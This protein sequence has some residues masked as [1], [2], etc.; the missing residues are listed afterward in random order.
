MELKQAIYGR[1]AT[2]AYTS[3]PVEQPL[4]EELIDAAIQ[5][6]SAINQQPWAF[7]IVRDQALLERISREA[8]ALM[9]RSSPAGLAS[10]HFEK[11]LGDQSFHIFYHA[12]ALILICAVE[13]SAWSQVDC[14]L[15]AQNL[16][17]AAYGKS[18]GSCWIGFAQGWLETDEGRA[19][20]DL[21]ENW[22]PMA[23]IIVGYPSG[24]TPAPPRNKPELRWLG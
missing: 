10:H 23:P 21:P 12:P 14:T 8:K 6:P 5:A 17:L 1:R 15:A 20:L 18:L 9:L 7:C 3:A 19:A 11:L 2:R 4:L 13:Q 16:M 22:K 24:A